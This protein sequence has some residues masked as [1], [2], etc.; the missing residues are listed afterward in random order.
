VLVGAIQIS[1]SSLPLSF[2]GGN[3]I[4]QK[5]E[6]REERRY[7]KLMPEVLLGAFA[8]VCRVGGFGGEC[9][10]GFISLLVRLLYFIL[11]D[12]WVG[13]GV[14]LPTLMPPRKTGMYLRH[15]R[16]GC[17]GSKSGGP[18]LDFYA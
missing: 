7:F 1:L 6:N 5:R 13:V 10:R 9:P 11:G 3:I 18:V 2:N 14:P 17:S 16:Y 12:G 15:V 8:V 4:Y